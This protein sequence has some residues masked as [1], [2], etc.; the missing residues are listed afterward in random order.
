[1]K[2]LT[3]QENVESEINVDG[4]IVNILGTS[5]RL[6]DGGTLQIWSDISEIRAKEREIAKSQKK[7]REAEEKIANAINGMP[8][9]ITMWDKDR[10]L[11]MI[12]DYG[13]EV[14]KKGNLNIQIGSTYEDYMNQSKKN[15]FLI[16]NNKI[17]EDTYYQNAVENRKNL[18]GVLTIETPPFYDGSIWQ[19]TSTR[20]PDG[21]VFSILSNITDLKKREVSLKQL[22]DAVEVTPNAI[23]LWDK[24]HKLVRVIK[25]LEKFKLNGDLISSQ[26]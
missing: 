15:N 20:L 11:I 21:G 7:V 2:E 13:K 22:S 10:K 16:F 19:S 4:Q 1:M 25:L 14:W 18:K 6:Q 26:V 9:G 17:D 23:L 5:T 8:H 12:N 3:G 24:D